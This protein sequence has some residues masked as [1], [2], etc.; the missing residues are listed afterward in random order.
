MTIINVFYR[1]HH[2]DLKSYEFVTLME[3]EDLI[4][5]SMPCVWKANWISLTFWHGDG[6]QGWYIKHIDNEI[7]Y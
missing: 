5:D 2:H 6:D 4:M 1:L 3:T 7:T